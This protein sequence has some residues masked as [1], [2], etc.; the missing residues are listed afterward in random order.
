MNFAISFVQALGLAAFLGWIFGG[1]AWGIGI[2]VSPVALFAIVVIFG[3]MKAW[4]E[5][6]AAAAPAR[7]AAAAA[8]RA[9]AKRLTAEKWARTQIV[10]PQCWEVRTGPQMVWVDAGAVLRCTT[11]HAKTPVSRRTPAGAERSTSCPSPTT[12]P[13]ATR[14]TGRTSGLR[15]TIPAATAVATDRRAP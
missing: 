14:P 12:T 6:Y 2:L 10:C 13:T 8:K 5:Q 11:C 3:L 4:D 15:G 1:P 9:E 7:A